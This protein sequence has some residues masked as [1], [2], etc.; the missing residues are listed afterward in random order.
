MRFTFFNTTG[1]NVNLYF[2]R[3]YY[4]ATSVGGYVLGTPQQ[5]FDGNFVFVTTFYDYDQS[6]WSFQTSVGQG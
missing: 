3:P 4:N 2:D 1:G 6:D 5:F